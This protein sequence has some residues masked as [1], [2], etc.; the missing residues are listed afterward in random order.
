MV[1]IQY[2]TQTHVCCHGEVIYGGEVRGAHHPPLQ[3][4]FC[5]PVYSLI[6][7]LHD[8][9]ILLP[10]CFAYFL[11][12]DSNSILDEGHKFISVSYYVLP[13]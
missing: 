6:G 4:R 3:E 9:V 8:G 7:G 12:L 5:T 13:S 11:L 2:D 1:I 10:E